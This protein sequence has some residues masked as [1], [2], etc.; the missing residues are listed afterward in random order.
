M[1]KISYSFLVL[2]CLHVQV[3]A[4]RAVVQL[5]YEET[6]PPTLGAKDLAKVGAGSTQ[7]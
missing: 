4:A 2:N 7:C 1:P 3:D 5:M 6:V